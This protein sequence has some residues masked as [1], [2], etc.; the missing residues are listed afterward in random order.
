MPAR[1]KSPTSVIH[2]EADEN[3]Y[4][5]KRRRRKAR[6]SWST[7]GM[8]YCAA[9]VLFVWRLA[10]D[11]ASYRAK[12]LELE[13]W[14]RA[15]KLQR[16]RNNGP[17]RSS[18]MSGGNKHEMTDDQPSPELEDEFKKLDYDIVHNVAGGPRFIRPHLLPP[19]PGQPEKE[20]LQKAPKMHYKMLVDGVD[21]FKATRRGAK[22]AWL[23]DDYED[24]RPPKVDYT[25][26]TYEYPKLMD[27]PP[28]KGGYPQLETLGDMFQRWP[29]NN[30]DEPP[31]PFV[32]RLLH[33]NYS[34]P[35]ERAAALKFRQAEL[36][37]KL[38]DVPEVT[39][40]GIQWTDDYVSQ[41]FDTPHSFLSGGPPRS[42]GKCQESANHFFAFFTPPLWKVS[43]M[44][45]PPTRNND[46]SF[47]QWA[48]HARYADAVG[49]AEDRPHFYWQAGVPKEERYQSEKQ[50]TFVSKDLPSFS[51]PTPTFFCFNPDEQKGIQCRFGERGV[52]AATHHDAGRNMVA[53]VTGAK[54]YILSP[55][56]E[57]SKLGVVTE[58]E[59]SIFRHSLLDFGNM[60][61]LETGEGTNMSAD[62]RAWLERAKGSMAVDTV[63]KAGEVM[64]SKYL[65]EC[66]SPIKS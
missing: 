60:V 31:T 34:N 66:I 18:R 43:T 50:W 3:K 37:F 1:K 15:V 55:P 58:R 42:Q 10:S 44:G 61:Y 62:E 51:S 23:Q 24:G 4:R 48:R 36:P 46:W 20:T 41:H 7:F 52:T 40:A 35:E 13:N 30:L 16:Q 53:M 29:Q 14:N 56:R 63:L 47:K 39:A 5:K 32:E 38:Y 64:Y 65:L 28:A 59:N 25:K 12:L 54:R 19:L 45:A 33:F 17:H 8:I 2:E 9:T 21:P 26:H 11:S 6:L 27:E 22:M 49:L 57:C